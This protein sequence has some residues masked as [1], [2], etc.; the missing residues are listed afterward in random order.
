MGPQCG[1]WKDQAVHTVEEICRVANTWHET[2]DGCPMDIDDRHNS[3]NDKKD[4][5]V[6]LQNYN[7]SVPEQ[8]QRIL[9]LHRQLN[10]R[11]DGINLQML[12]SLLLQNFYRGKLGIMIDEL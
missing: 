5:L 9:K 12:V 11:Q 2:S 8:R 3:T 4:L 6:M 1:G 10:V 7:A